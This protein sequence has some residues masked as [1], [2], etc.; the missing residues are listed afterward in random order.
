MN[1]DG[2]FGRIL[3]KL[4]ILVAALLFVA[5]LISCGLYIDIKMNG[6][7]SS[8]PELSDADKKML[9]RTVASESVTYD[10]DLIEPI[11]VGIKSDYSMVA[12][13]PD[14]AARHAVENAVYSSLNLLFSGTSEAL[15]FE[16]SGEK[17]EYIKKIK[18]S[19]NYMLLGFY[20]DIPS[21]AILPC[22]SNNYDIGGMKKLFF[23]KY[24]FL[25]PDDYGSLYGVSVSEDLSVNKL[26]PAE[27][28]SFNKLLSGTYDVSD[29]YCYFE[30][31]ENYLVR[32]ML[33]SSFLSNKFK[34][35]NF[36]SDFGKKKTSEWVEELFDLFSINSSLV[37]EYPSN[38]NTEIN[39]IDDEREISISDDG[40]VEFRVA[41]DDGIY[42]DEFL[43]YAPGTNSGYTFN[44]K[45]FAVKSIVNK[46]MG[47]KKTFSYTIVGV[48]YD[49]VTGEFTVYLKSLVEGVFISDKEYDAKFE[50]KKDSLTYA[51]FY[52]VNCEELDDYNIVLP[53]KYSA[54][55]DDSGLICPFLVP[56]DEESDIHVVKWAKKSPEKEAAK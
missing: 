12:A 6:K 7:T 54:L 53:Q 52:A 29:G 13:C 47:G 35:S 34:I 9:L 36:A 4:E 42:L 21:Y 40:I 38:N 30:Y 39:Y 3:S 44:D 45:I 11:F 43:G 16:S 49:N 32:P 48:D 37:K 17:N 28:V 19:N 5:M 26:Y 27:S 50:I 23:V 56:E 14:D 51:L 31:D 10:D 33:T 25:L 20:S 15:T 55:G 2:R 24:L 8:L 18:T 46:L 1:S 22:L 41:D